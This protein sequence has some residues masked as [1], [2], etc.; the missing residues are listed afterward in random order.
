M[1][2]LETRHLWESLQSRWEREDVRGRFPG[3][4]RERERETERAREPQRERESTRQGTP[5]RQI[6]G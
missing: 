5:D 1:Q 4:I 2:V 3:K 6:H